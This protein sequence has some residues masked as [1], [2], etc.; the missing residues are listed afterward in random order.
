MPGILLPGMRRPRRGPKP[1]HAAQFR[2]EPR[3]LGMPVRRGHQEADPSGGVA[4]EPVVKPV[5]PAAA[6]RGAHTTSRKPP[7][8]AA[9]PWERDPMP[10]DRGLEPA[11]AG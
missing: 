1:Q 10:L 2:D 9:T 4:D 7:D 3:R 11:R 5:R 8:P 6:G